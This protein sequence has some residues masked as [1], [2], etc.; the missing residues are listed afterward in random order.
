[1]VTVFLN[2]I[3]NCTIRESSIC[4]A[5][6]L[7]VTVSKQSIRYRAPQ[8]PMAAALSRTAVPLAKKE[9]L[10]LRDILVIIQATQIARMFS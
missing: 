9:I 6:V 5:F 10:I 7:I 1:M 4:D 2:E 8:H 3:T